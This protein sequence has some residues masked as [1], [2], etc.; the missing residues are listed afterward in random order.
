MWN[1]KKVLC[2][3]NSILLGVNR[4]HL[5]FGSCSISLY[6]LEI[7]HKFRCQRSSDIKVDLNLNVEVKNEL[8]KTDSMKVD[9]HIF[10]ILCIN[11][12]HCLILNVLISFVCV[13]FIILY[14]LNFCSYFFC[15]VGYCTFIDSFFCLLCNSLCSS[16]SAKE[17]LS[18]FTMWTIQFVS[19]C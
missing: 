3:I 5:L 4:I 16:R 17:P 18:A 11:L 13:P 2:S 1:I 6:N 14:Q 12:F 7:K 10:R 8:R 19:C 15:F 9:P